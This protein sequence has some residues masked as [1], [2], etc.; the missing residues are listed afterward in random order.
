M[1]R[2][3]LIS[4][5]IIIALLSACTTEESQKDYKIITTTYSEQESHLLEF[6]NGKMTNDKTYDLRGLEFYSNRNDLL[7]YS[8]Y[9]NKVINA[10]TSESF[11]IPYNPYDMIDDGN[12]KIIVHRNGIDKDNFGI[13]N[14]IRYDENFNI[15]KKSADLTGVPNKILYYDNQILVLNNRRDEK[16]NRWTE[17]SVFDDENLTLID[18][19]IIDDMIYGFDLK[20]HNDDLSI[21]GHNSLENE[22]LYIATLALKN[23]DENFMEFDQSVMWITDCFYKDELLYIVNEYSVIVINSDN[24]IDSVF[25]TEMSIIDFHYVNEDL[26]YILHGDY[27]KHVFEVFTTNS[28]FEIIDEYPIIDIDTKPTRIVVD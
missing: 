26:I 23:S 15:I 19:W 17:V 21:F 18:E 27:D 22:N 12:E 4:F 9:D 28:S 24:K 20:I 7:L 10:H 13:Y 6:S 2:L 1:K 16:Q 25:E 14:I 5:I 11:D 8:A 3:I